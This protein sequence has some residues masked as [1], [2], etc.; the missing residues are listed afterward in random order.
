MIRGRYQPVLKI[1]SPCC[2]K[3]LKVIFFLGLAAA[4]GGAHSLPADVG[5][6]AV[7]TLTTAHYRFEM[8]AE[9]AAGEQSLVR[10]LEALWMFYQRAMGSLV[11]LN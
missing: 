1:V 4:S 10:A 9:E 11:A 5:R 3:F 7:H 6:N 8:A 2:P